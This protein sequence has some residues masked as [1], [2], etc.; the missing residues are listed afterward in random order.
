[1]E[2]GNL[3]PFTFKNFGLL[4][5]ALLMTLMAGCGRRGNLEPP[6][7][8]HAVRSQHE[9]SRSVERNQTE[10]LEGNRAASGVVAPDQPF[11]L[12]PLL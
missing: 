10:A 7:D 3:I 4:T 2:I 5:A 8:S 11:V 6:P 12:D 1:M 9:P